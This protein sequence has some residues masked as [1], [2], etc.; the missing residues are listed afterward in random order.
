M[1]ARLISIIVAVAA[2]VLGV[3]YQSKVE[4][5]LFVVLGLG[6]VIQPIEDFPYDCRRIRHPLLE[7]CE[8]MWL[9]DEG[10]ALYAA[11]SSIIGRMGWAPG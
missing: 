10:R 7:S 11:C 1:A 2:V 8:D 5:I 3:A 4:N 6:R 9:D